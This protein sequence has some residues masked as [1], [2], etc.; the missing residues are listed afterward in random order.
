VINPEPVQRMSMKEITSDVETTTSTQE[1][2]SNVDSVA[3]KLRDRIDTA[4]SVDQAKAIR[5]DI[6]SQK[7][8][9]GTA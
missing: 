3:D 8:L 1:P 5:V 2:A 9:L 6:E 7:A 4:D